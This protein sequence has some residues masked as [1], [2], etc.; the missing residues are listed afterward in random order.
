MRYLLVFFLCSSFHAYNQIEYGIYETRYP[1]EYPYHVYALPQKDS[2]IVLWVECFDMETEKRDAGFLIYEDELSH[3]NDVLTEVIDKYIEWSAIAWE[4]K[5]TSFNKE[6]TSVNLTLQS[7]FFV[8][9]IANF[10]SSTDI[11]FDFIVSDDT[12]KLILNSGFL[13]SNSNEVLLSHGW[14]IFFTS[15]EELEDF[16]SIFSESNFQSFKELQF[17][18]PPNVDELFK[19]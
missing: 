19:D 12:Y 10:N 5:V 15:L 16:K 11:N 3:F 18:D 9:E 8:D 4:N 14:G 13:I 2:S 17:K 6:I 7:Y 1:N